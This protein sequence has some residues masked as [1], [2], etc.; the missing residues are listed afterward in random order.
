MAQ[1]EGAIFRFPGRDGDRRCGFQALQGIALVVPRHRVFEPENAVRFEQPRR[2]YGG[3]EIPA[4]V[5]VE[6]EIGI[7]SRRVSNDPYA[8]G[9]LLR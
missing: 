8:L 6:H 5:G 1:T 9:I 7:R 2:M 4:L 3:E